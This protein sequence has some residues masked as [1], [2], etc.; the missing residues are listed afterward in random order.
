MIQRSR[1][2][3]Q[4]EGQ[5]QHEHMSNFLLRHGS[6]AISSSARFF[7]RLSAISLFAQPDHNSRSEKWAD[8]TMMI[9]RAERCKMSFNPKMNRSLSDRGRGQ[10]SCRICLFVLHLLVL[11]LHECS[12]FAP[13]QEC[14]HHFRRSSFSSAQ[15]FL[16]IDQEASGKKLSK[17]EQYWWTLFA[18][19]DEY[20]RD[21]G[22]CN[23]PFTF[24][25]NPKLGRWVSNQRQLYK[26]KDLSDERIEAL[27]RIGFEWR[28]P[29]GNRNDDK[30]LSRLAQLKEYKREYGNTLVP[31]TLIRDDGN[32]YRELAMWV[33]EQRTQYRLLKEGKQHSRLSDDRMSKLNEIGFI[34][35]AQEAAWEE[36][37]ADLVEFKATHG[38]TDVPKFWHNSHLYNFVRNQRTFHKEYKKGKITHMTEERIQRLENMGFLLRSKRTY[39]WKMYFGDLCDF[40]NKNGVVPIPQA[41]HMVLYRWTY[42]Q[43]KEYDKFVKGEKTNMDEE[44]I[45]DLESI[46]FFEVY[47]NTKPNHK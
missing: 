32:K 30:W 20:K 5:P 4:V 22:D 18:E 11:A 39:E 35:S 43:K 40:Y 1:R 2:I 15:K 17:R 37:F 28:R 33:V 8:D 10:A 42:N 3:G 9:T 44:R 24:Y 41:K 19:L 38:H 21:H 23:V 29:A 27:E 25:P 31:S 14:A 13:P 12:G 16:T 46:G 36:S 26:R 7:Q 45:R 34:W 6:S 47:G